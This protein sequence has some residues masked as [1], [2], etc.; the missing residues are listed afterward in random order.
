MMI[1]VHLHKC[2]QVPP[3]RLRYGP[4]NKN[5]LRLV[6]NTSIRKLDGQGGPRT[7]ESLLGRNLS[8]SK[9]WS[10]NLFVKKNIWLVEPA[11]KTT[12]LPSRFSLEGPADGGTLLPGR[13]GAD[14]RDG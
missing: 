4:N 3:A 1:F 8:R 2:F 5:L 14:H 9:F 6:T 10:Q 7:E 11:L 13:D 12:C